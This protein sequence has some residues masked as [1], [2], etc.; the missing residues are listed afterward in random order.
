[1]AQP[2]YEQLLGIIAAKDRQIAPLETRVAQVEGLLEKATRAGKRQAAPFSKGLPKKNPK[3][4]G[5]RAARTTA[6]KPI[7]LF[8]I[9][10]RMRSST[11]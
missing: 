10:D 5:A 6:R 7:A 2:T 11:S 4:P 3:S 8:R 1:M 9:K